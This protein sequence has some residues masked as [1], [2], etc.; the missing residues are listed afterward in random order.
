MTK[1]P[2]Y[3][4]A[5]V[6]EQAAAILKQV[7]AEAYPNLDLQDGGVLA[8]LFTGLGSLPYAYMN[9]LLDIF[10]KSSSLYAVANNMDT[11]NPLIVN[12]IVSN[13]GA[14]LGA[15]ENSRGTITLVLST[16]DITSISENTVFATTDGLEF[17]ASASFTGVP[18]ASQVTT[19]NH[20]LIS[21]RSDGS[22]SFNITAVATK[23][24]TE[25]NI[26]KDS[27]LIPASVPSN[28]IRAYAESDFSGG[29]NAETVSELLRRIQYNLTSMTMSSRIAIAALFKIAVPQLV[30]IS[31]IGMGDREMLRDRYN[32]E[33]F[34]TGGKVDIYVQT[35]EKP[36][37]LTIVK[38]ATLVDAASGIWQISMGKDDAP[39]FYA[40]LSILPVGSTASGSKTIISDV[41]GLDLTG[42]GFRPSVNNIQEGAYSRFQTAVIRFYDTE[43]AAGLVV[44]D[45]R[46]YNVTVY[47]QEH[48]DTLQDFI[49]NYYV[50]NPNG[51]YLVRAAIPCFVSVNLNIRKTSGAS[52]PNTAAMAAA[53]AKTVNSTGFG[54]K[55]SSSEIIKACSP[56]LTDAVVEMPVEMLGQLHKPDGTI[57]VYRR[58]N[59]IEIDEDLS[60]CTT[61]RTVLF[62][63][64]PADVSISVTE[65]SEVHL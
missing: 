30:D 20:R 60:N 32:I 2:D 35:A 23:V 14:E 56:Y 38:E 37:Q 54:G 50:R 31:I 62:F 22:Y 27:E 16:N 43:M 34:G 59:E 1:L 24:G 29:I 42:T 49:A 12:N 58:T 61:G 25:Y 15:G 41:R 9:Y 45:T 39:G 4:N 7:V 17:K 18:L 52:N 10:Q 55:L 48:L 53:I 21:Q 11:A 44:G 28:F 13:Y 3:I 47:M 46:E 65:L 8:T 63:L 57:V 6:M 19:A 51:D 33:Q 36:V 40:V 26:P 5:D 64:D